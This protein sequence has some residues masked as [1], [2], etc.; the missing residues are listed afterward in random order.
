MKI[1]A[2]LI[3]I[4]FIALKSTAQEITITDTLKQDYALGKMSWDEWQQKAGWKDYSAKDYAIPFEIIEKIKK[5]SN[6]R[7]ISYVIVGASWCGDSKKGM[8][9]IFK[10]FSA[11]GIKDSAVTLIG[12]DREKIDPENLSLRYD[13]EKVPTLIVFEGEKELGR[14]IE[15]PLLSWYEDLLDILK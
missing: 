5:S 1:T 9:E 14:I 11:L 13:I 10:L 4:F 15:I 2:L 6:G 12:V 3:I 7:S 8:P